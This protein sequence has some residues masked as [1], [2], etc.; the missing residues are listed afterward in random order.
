MTEYKFYFGYSHCFITAECE[1][2]AVLKFRQLYNLSN[3]TIW[4]VLPRESTFI[5]IRDYLITDAKGVLYYD[6]EVKPVY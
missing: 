1:R 3:W 6:C 5:C 2:N 4:Y